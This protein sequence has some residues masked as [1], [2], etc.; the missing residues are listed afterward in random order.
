MFIF[1]TDQGL[2]EYGFAAV[3]SSVLQAL[4]TLNFI[5]PSCSNSY[6]NKQLVLRAGP[7]KQNMKTSPIFERRR[8]GSPHI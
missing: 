4:I 6:E 1:S 7:V 5:F 3:N 2:T 8:P